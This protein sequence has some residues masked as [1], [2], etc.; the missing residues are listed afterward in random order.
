M[1]MYIY[2]Y[3]P[4]IYIYICILWWLIIGFLTLPHVSQCL[5]DSGLRTWNSAGV[6]WANVSTLACMEGQETWYNGDVV[7]MVWKR[8]EWNGME[9]NGMYGGHHPWDRQA[10]I[11]VE[12]LSTAWPIIGSAAL[13]HFSKTEPLVGPTPNVIHLRRWMP[14]CCLHLPQRWYHTPHSNSAEIPSAIAMGIFF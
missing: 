12:E 10:K 1:P 6:P 3:H 2:I 7:G 13:I 9:W 4:F 11:C 8:M 5:N 14:S